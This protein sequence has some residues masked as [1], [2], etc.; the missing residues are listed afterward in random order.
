METEAEMRVVIIGGKGLIGQALAKELGS[1]G[2]QVTILT[3][4]DTQSQPAGETWLNWDGKDAQKLLGLIEGQEAIVNLAGESIGKSRW[5]NQRKEKILTSRLEPCIALAEAMTKTRNGPRMLVQASAVGYY[6]TGTSEFN[7]N[8]EQGRDWLASICQKWENSTASL[9]DSGTRRVVIRSGVVLAREGGVL[10]QL[11]LPF[12]FFIG[13]PVGSGQQW[14][15]W[16]HLLDEVKAIRFL[17][18]H[19]ACHGVYNLTAPEPVMNRSMG[20]TLAHVLQRP[21]WFPLP[22][23]ALKLALGEMSTLVLDGQNVFPTKLLQTGF[24][25]EFPTLES[26]LQDL[27]G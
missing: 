27:C 26:A 9:E 6:G 8:S 4:G 22:A 20:K 14:V 2:H 25:F 24:Q 11:S 18:E 5:T 17:I 10:S 12:R 15:S 21:F 16:I 1:H 7:E 3:R 19:E 13:G 23:F